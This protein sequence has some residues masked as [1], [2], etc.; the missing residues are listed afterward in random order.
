MNKLLLLLLIITG[1]LHSQHARAQGENNVWAFGDSIG[2]DFNSGT[3]T[4][5]STSIISGESGA[6]IC[7]PEGR[8][9]MYSGTYNPF[10]KSLG[11]NI[12]WDSTHKEMPE[13][14]SLIGNKYT[15]STQGAVIIPFLDGSNKYYVFLQA[16]RENLWDER[17]HYLRYSVV[18]MD[19]RGGLG[20]V[21]PGMKNIIIDSFISE[22]LSVTKG[23]GCSV[24]LITH[25]SDTNEFHSFNISAA[26]VN[27]TPVVSAFLSDRTF[28]YTYPP[29]CSYAYGCMDISLDGKRIASS[30]NTAYK[31]IEL[32]DFNAATGI[33]SNQRIIDSLFSYSLQ[34]SPDG[35]KL[36]TVTPLAQ[37]NL[38]LLPSISAV[39]ASRTVISDT[40]TITGLRNGPDN[41][42]Y[43]LVRKP[44]SPGVS[45][46]LHRLNFPNLA[47]PG[48]GYTHVL[49]LPTSTHYPTNFGLNTIAPPPTDTITRKKDT[50]ICFIPFAEIK[51]DPG[52]SGYIW[53]DGTKGRIYTIKSPGKIWVRMRKGCTLYVD[54]I[55]VSAKPLDTVF[56]KKDTT[57]CFSAPIK[58]TAPYGKAY[59]WYDNDT[60]RTKSFSAGGAY[61]VG[62]YN[63]DE[64][65]YF[66]DTFN[67]KSSTNF[68]TTY[69][70][71]DTIVC[72]AD[73]LL[74][75][76][77]TGYEHYKWYSGSTAVSQT[78]LSAGNYWVIAYKNCSIRIDSF[79]IKSKPNDSIFYRKDT[80]ACLMQPLSLSLN[81]GYKSYL[82]SDGSTATNLT[83]NKAG[84]FWAVSS[85]NCSIR[86]D[87]FVIQSKPN[88][89]SFFKTDSIVCF[90][91]KITLNAPAGF[92]NHIWSDN[93]TASL[94]DINTD[95]SIWVS[96]F[97]EDCTVRMDSFDIRFINFDQGMPDL[98]SICGE[99]KLTLDASTNNASYLWQDGSTLATYE[100]SKEG[101]YIVLIT[102]G[103][104]TSKH[105][106]V[107]T[108]RDFTIS[109]G[110]DQ[111]LCEG[112]PVSI[113]PGIAADS[114]KWQD[115]NNSNVYEVTETGMYWLEVSK[116]NCIARDTVKIE[117]IRC[118]H[119]ISIPNAF[120]PDKNGRNDFFR[121]MMEC[122]VLSYT[123]K[124]FNR[125]GQEVFASTKPSDKWDGTFS[126][127][128]LDLGVYYYFLKVQFDYPGA[129]EE[130]YKGDI[131][132]IR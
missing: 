73:H 129:K 85:N 66:I 22:K 59:K 70:I 53:Q 113:N 21:V 5:I 64:C 32:F 62:Y 68:D 120:T 128:E 18:D 110:E 20:D 100:V 119:C 101:N 72:M 1:S 37:Y 97:N 9:L 105:T 43:V 80:L 27:T 112:T 121:P 65:K 69:N 39:R 26:G 47:A 50:A 74:L 92:T 104:C 115:G 94:I 81:P 24:W 116:G 44:I 102:V 103:P 3:P 45:M 12:I 71:V 95:K 126:N 28:S 15:S 40:G 75:S 93:T 76:A 13:S 23:P 96:S 49:T 14:D 83:V 33:V 54:T 107:I 91:D 63:G 89:T 109:L 2:L 42:M 17:D 4:L 99:T 61:W 11:R 132:L 111:K 51:A 46:A 130:M 84:L 87:S 41:K 88:D 127:K 6:S 79:N 10:T 36:Y 90:E 77:G 52:F 67:L 122:P 48:C 29:E 35:N 19:L 106:T 8:L 125:Y 38:N 123:L 30:R 56:N 16:S 86:L 124:I 108:K 25:R 82:W 31:L 55:N 58:I 78:V 57:I 114:Y 60:N 118:N 117:I 131:S 98:D 7:S 34:F